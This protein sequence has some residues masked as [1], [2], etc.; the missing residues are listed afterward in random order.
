MNWDDFVQSL[1]EDEIE[2]NDDILEGLYEIHSNPLNLNNTDEDQLKQLYFL[3]Q[4]QITAI[5]YYIQHNYPVRSLGELM[6]IRELDYITRMRMMLFCY[7]KDT[8][9]EEPKLT[10]NNLLTR[11]TNELTF[12]SDF[13]MYTKEGYKTKSDSVLLKS[14]NKIYQGNRY[15]HSLR[16]QFSSM[17]HVFAGF[18]LE[19]D[20]G[21]RYI[22]YLSGYIM[23]EN[24]GSI[25]TFLIGDYKL[26]YGQGLVVNNSMSFGKLS[27]IS[28]LSYLNKGISKHASTSEFNHF[29]GIATNIKFSKDIRFTAFLSYQNI[30]G[31]L[32]ASKDITQQI[33]ASSL[34]T[35]G[36][37]RTKSE[38]DKKGNIH[39]L[40]MGGN[41]QYT[42]NNINLGIT[43]IYTHLSIPLK[44]KC[45]TPSTLYRKYN[46]QGNR[47]I[48]TGTSYSY[49]SN[50]F[51]FQGETA[52]TSYYNDQEKANIAGLATVNSIIYS[53]NNHTTL[54][55]LHRHYGVK[56][57]TLYGNSI[58]ENSSP[59]N[60]NGIY[61]GAKAE[62]WENIFLEAYIDG[63]CFPY[64]KY[65]VS[66]R[67]KGIDGLCQMSYK[68]SNSSS[69]Q[70]RY[71]IKSK[72]K[73]YKISSDETALYYNT[74]QNI[75]LQYNQQLT[76]NISL[77][78]VINASFLF[79]PDIDNEHGIVLS[80]NIRW[81][82]INKKQ[83]GQ[84]IDFMIAYFNT[85]S[86]SSRVYIYEPSLYYSNGMSSLYYKGIRAVLSVAL[87][88]TDNLNLTG[89]IS[90]IKYFNKKS[91]SS[92]LE[93]INASH[94][95]D[96][97]I[98][99]RWKI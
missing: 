83:S 88:I 28:S 30:D 89:K 90:T 96:I 92:G 3:S 7:V 16:Y 43:T 72:Q 79:N 35:D 53:L 11:N 62:L 54:T 67:S 20:P 27:S 91:I 60:E 61:L 71:R 68:P 2:N 4:K 36:L 45:D 76:N 47:F 77:K 84:R 63:F 14:P 10:L 26:S 44:P 58:S 94:K 52:I 24:I 29:R 59:Q 86:Y 42:H 98:Q 75:R 21:E 56:Y 99:L 48:A 55:L 39:E 37:H 34:K 19:K 87:P 74:S 9:K 12:R 85:D 82:N 64:K 69:I 70:V 46:L 57:A 33:S 31:T 49:H 73:N 23:M 1:Y 6:L 51:V 78:T 65:Q 95:E 50:K 40:S 15:Y 5:I 38:I 97:Q 81:N 93:M 17:K 22:D 41:I 80:Q 32:N 66:D 18:Q 13:P 8:D 25:H